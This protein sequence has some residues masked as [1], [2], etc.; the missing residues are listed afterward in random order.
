MKYF[1]DTTVAMGA[2]H[3][4]IKSKY[5]QHWKLELYVYIG[6]DNLVCL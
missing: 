3:V 1:R 6:L 2:T 4:H 5:N